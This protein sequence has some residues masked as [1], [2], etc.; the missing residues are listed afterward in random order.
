MTADQLYVYGG[1]MFL[2]GCIV[3]ALG[4]VFRRTAVEDTTIDSVQGVIDV[5]RR[6]ERIEGGPYAGL[7][8]GC[9]NAWIR[10]EYGGMCLS[11]RTCV[12]SEVSQ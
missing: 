12:E 3:L 11:C 9:A 2:L 5:I 8:E 1:L 7:H 4:L 10:A 6:G